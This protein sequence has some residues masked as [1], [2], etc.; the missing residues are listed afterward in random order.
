MT[1]ADAKHSRKVMAAM[2]RTLRVASGRQV[3]TGMG[4]GVP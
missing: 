1:A 2:G 3:D 4:T